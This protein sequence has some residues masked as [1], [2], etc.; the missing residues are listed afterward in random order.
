MPLTKCSIE[1]F[2]ILIIES[3]VTVLFKFL[4][5]LIVNMTEII[6]FHGIG[7]HLDLSKGVCKRGIYL[8]LENST[9]Y[10]LYCVCGLCN[11][12][13]RVNMLSFNI[14][15]THVCILTQKL[16]LEFQKNINLTLRDTCKQ[17]HQ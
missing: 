1:N 15:V 14:S 16:C 13:F 9:L 7:E 2:I 10:I 4:N 11:F 17:L 12:E 8:K 6:T 3:N 5:L